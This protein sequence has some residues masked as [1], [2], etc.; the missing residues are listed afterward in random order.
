MGWVVR[1]VA[2]GGVPA[3]VTDEMADDF[4]HEIG[5]AV[6]VGTPEIS[7]VAVYGATLFFDEVETPQAAI[8]RGLANFDAAVARS[9]ITPLPIASVEAQ[10]Y[11]EQDRELARGDPTP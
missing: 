5:A 10:T 2:A 9:G 11:E 8:E 6:G 7:D 1:I 4:F 3:D